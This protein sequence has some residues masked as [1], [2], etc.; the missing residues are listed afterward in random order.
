MEIMLLII[1]FIIGYLFTIAYEFC[2]N[3]I[4]SK[5]NKSPVVR[6][7]EYHIHHSIYGLIL[8]LLFFIIQHPVI[9]GSAVG[10]IIRH[11]I[12]EKRFTFIDK[13]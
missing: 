4:E 3:L 12:K 6:F 2:F 13:D 1:G 7:K 11:T 10:S 9:I 5:V 8:I